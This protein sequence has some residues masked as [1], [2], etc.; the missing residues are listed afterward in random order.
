MEVN[1]NDELRP[2]GVEFL[3]NIGI[4]EVSNRTFI[5]EAELE[6]FLNSEFDGINKTKAM[7]FIQILEREYNIDLGDL[8]SRYILYLEEKQ[9]EQS[10]P[11]QSL[12]NG[13]GKK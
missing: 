13:R 7:G 4:K 3:K 10:E 8:K 1:E 12:M 5:H 2:A 11:K 9:A 6:K